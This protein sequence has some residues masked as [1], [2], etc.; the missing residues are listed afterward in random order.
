MQ[1]AASYLLVFVAFLTLP[2]YVALAQDASST[3]TCNFDEDKQLAVEYQKITVNPKKFAF[4]R[5]LPYNK[6]WTPGKKPMTLFTNTPVDI[7]GNKI[8]VGAYTM[9]VLPA[10]KQWTL[11]ISK[12]TD[13]TGAYDEQ[14]DLARIPMGSGELTSPESQFSVYFAHVSPKECS[15]RLSLANLGTW[16]IFAEK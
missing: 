3:A 15:M 14:K 1:R 9:F 12:S 4:G 16:V 13:M 7:G 10:Q 8:P 6:V 11:I 2:S 5:D